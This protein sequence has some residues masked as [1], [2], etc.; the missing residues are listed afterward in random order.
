M[1]KWLISA[2]A[3]IYDHASAFVKYGYI[4]WR[5]RVNYNVG[6]EV[7]IYCTRPYQ[8]IMYKTMVIEKDMSFSQIT[9]DKE[10]WKDINEY[11]RSQS[12]RYARLKLIEQADN[13]YLSLLKLQENGLTAAPQGPVRMKDKLAL[14]VDAYMKENLVHGIFPE[15]DLPED[16]YEGVKCSVIVNKYERSSIARQKCIEKHGY[17]CK[18][19]GIDFEETYGIVGKN[20]IHVHHIVPISTIGK[21]YK[22]NYEKDLVPICPNCHAMLHRG[23]NGTVLEIEDLRKMLK[24]K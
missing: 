21:K 4:D 8:K 6:D 13:P 3:R 11:T 15:T 16:C 10:F 18:V 17:R 14:Y 7:Y 1:Q 22:I 23:E 20:F 9:D 12:G 24:R 5:Q 2:N 19:C